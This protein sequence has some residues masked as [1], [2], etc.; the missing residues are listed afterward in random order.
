M[1]FTK[2]QAEAVRARIDAEPDFDFSDDI[3]D[4]VAD[5]LSQSHTIDDLRRALDRRD[6]HI[7]RLRA[8]LDSAEGGPE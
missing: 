2:E 6:A 8:A 4:L 3:A 5:W 7:S 1:N